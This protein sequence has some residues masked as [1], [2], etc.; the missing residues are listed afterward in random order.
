MQAQIDCCWVIQLIK[1]HPD[2]MIE[3]I[4]RKM[5]CSIGIATG[6]LGVLIKQG[7]VLQKIILLGDVQ[8]LAY[9]LV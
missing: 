7:I 8:R 2:I 5:R 6:L 3:D 1:Y 4:A 9:F